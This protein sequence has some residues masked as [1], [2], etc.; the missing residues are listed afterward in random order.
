MK[1]SIEVI[2]KSIKN[3]DMD[4]KHVLFSK[5]ALLYEECGNDEKAKEYQDL[6]IKEDEK[7]PF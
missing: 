1:K 3:E 5:L 7:L 2:E 4:N 6:V